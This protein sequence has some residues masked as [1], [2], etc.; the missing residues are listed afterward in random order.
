MRLR[1][2]GR[3][4]SGLLHSFDSGLTLS[5][6]KTKLTNF[7]LLPFI[8]QIAL[9]ELCYSVLVIPHFDEYILFFA[10]FMLIKMLVY[11]VPI[12]HLL[13]FLPTLRKGSL[14]PFSEA[15][16]SMELELRGV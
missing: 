11:I 16:L 12:Q 5:Y 10:L 7:Q 3:I 2:C 14:Y 4:T 1:P 9:I 6:E 8:T 15:C 13:H